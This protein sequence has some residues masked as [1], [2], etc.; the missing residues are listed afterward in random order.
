MRVV[1]ECYEAAIVVELRAEHGLENVFGV[2]AAVSCSSR[3]SFG[4]V[5]CKVSF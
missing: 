3:P 1:G 5:G 4:R 2:E